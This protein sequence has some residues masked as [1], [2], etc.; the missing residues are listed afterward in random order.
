MKRPFSA[1]IALF[2][3]PLFFVSGFSAMIYQVVWQRMLGIFGGSDIRS[4]TIVTA[5]YLLGLGVGSFVGS[6]FADRLSSRRSVFAYALCNLGIAA[7]GVFSYFLYY[8]ILFQRLQVLAES[9]VVMLVTVFISLLWPTTLMGLTLPFISR[10]V[11]TKLTGVASTISVLYAINT[12]GAALGALICGWILIGTFGFVQTLNIGVFLS[13]TVGLV[14]WLLSRQFSDEP[15]VTTAEKPNLS[16]L[17]I[18]RSVWRWAL[19]V[20]VS[21]YIFISLEIIWFRLLDFILK[22][23]AYTFGHLLGLVL[24]GDALGSLYAT[25]TLHRIKDPQRVFF[26]LQGLIALYSICATALIALL[27]TSDGLLAQYNVFGDGYSLLA[28][29]RSS[30]D[31]GLLLAFFMIY[32]MLPVL[33]LLP[34]SFMVGMYYPI[35]QKGIQTDLA[36]VGQ[37]VALVEGANIVGN[38]LGS[39]LTGVVLLQFVGTSNALKIIA[40][41]GAVFMVLLLR[42][43]FMR[44]SAFQKGFSFAITIGLISMIVFFPD[45]NRYW[46]QMHG[47]QPDEYFDVKE[48]A[49][50]V[51]AIVSNGSDMSIWINGRG[52]G[53]VNNFTVFHSYLGVVPG[54]LHTNPENVLAIGMGSGNTPYALGLNPAIKRV[55]VVEIVG[56]GYDVLRNFAAHPQGNAF[57]SMFNDP[58][59]TMIIGDG[60]HIL[61]TSDIKYDVVVVDALLPWTS[62]AGL[63]YSQEFYT[64][65]LAQLNDGGLIIQ[66]RPTERTENTFLSVFPYVLNLENIALL[67]SNQPIALDNQFLSN[68]LDRPDVDQYL[69]DGN[70][71]VTEIRRW[72]DITGFTS[73]EPQTPRQSGEVNTDLFPKDEYYLNNSLGEV[74]PAV[75][76]TILQR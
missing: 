52:Q 36:L 28:N 39:I 73:W 2:V 57:Q 56:S 21:G 53:S 9:P 63:L 16:L 44:V 13:A 51:A 30:N 46:A 8:E 70:V 27:M 55:D 10:A 71:N 74:Q 40:I 20:M 75:P 69:R 61:V 47:A 66:W 76:E 5:A 48:D 4:V 60:R 12:L 68:Q 19:L 45:Q 38:T 54:L 11:A 24:I 62:Q 59:Y 22:S 26:Q 41:L 37:R 31:I 35:V 3:A 42:D 49:S 33:L 72:L 6:G 23:N 65:I 34:P 17:K 25:K 58:R 64:A 7:F 18:P 32:I 50:G 14:G 67:G 15:Y 43:N 1:N 29:L